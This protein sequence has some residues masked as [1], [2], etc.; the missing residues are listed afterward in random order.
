MFASGSMSREDFVED[1]HVRNRNLSAII[2]VNKLFRIILNF[3]L[4]I[5]FYYFFH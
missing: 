3:G 2:I 5:Y 4:Y 1:G